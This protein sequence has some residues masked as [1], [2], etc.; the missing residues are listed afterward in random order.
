MKIL[1]TGCNG[2]LGQKMI[3]LL[4]SVP[5]VTVIATAR[6][7]LAGSWSVPFELMNI[8][9]ASAVARVVT[10]HAPDVIVH[11]AAMTQ[12][13]ICEQ[14]KE[15]CYRVNVSGVENMIEASR[16]CN[17]HLV[18]VSTDFIFDGKRDRLAEGDQP[19]PVNYY[20][21]CKWQAEQLVVASNISWSIVR[22]VLVYGIIPGVQRSNIVTWVKQSLEQGKQ[23]RVVNDQWR[24][25]TLAEDLAYGCYLVAK[26]R[27]NG[28]Y[29]ISGKD[30]VSIYEIAM[31]TAAFFGL[32]D[33]LITPVESAALPQP[34]K[35]PLRTGFDISK[36]TSELGYHPH[37]LAEG[38]SVLASQIGR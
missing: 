5:E 8:T 19:G 16:T 25:P 35:R 10:A 21:Q 9:D 18:H 3:S 12:V 36:A 29:H 11:A 27:A 15:E 2:L 34:A 20:G 30:F 22:T 24:T 14:N 32:D 6:T 4:A 1:V 33:S 31:Q 37:S 26:K 23:I 17:A 28:I 38:I 7:P 13:D